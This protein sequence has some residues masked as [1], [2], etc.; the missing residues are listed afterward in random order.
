MGSV[1]A[2]VVGSRWAR[3]WSTENVV[4][5]HAKHDLA[6]LPD[7]ATIILDGVCPYDGPA[8]V[9]ESPWDWS[10]AASL[11]LGKQIEGDIGVASLQVTDSGLTT[12]IYDMKNSYAYGHRLFVYRPDARRVIPVPDLR[13][14]KAYWPDHLS[15]AGKCPRGYPAMGVL[16][17]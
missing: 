12:Q 17:W 4:L 3:A 2:S 11:K 16:D 7:G 6:A 1:N 13:A 15:A 5:D 9:F 10:S 8:I 14:A